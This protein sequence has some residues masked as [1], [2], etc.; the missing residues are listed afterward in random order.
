MNKLIII[1][2]TLLMPL[3]AAAERGT[4]MKV[5]VCGE[6]NVLIKM[7]GGMYIA[8]E[9]FSGVILLEGEVVYGNLKTYGFEQISTK[10]KESGTFFVQECQS[11]NIGDA[12]KVLCD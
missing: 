8:A 3:Y 12:T 6:G 2:I 5:D 1:L 11:D 4:V 10:N 9:Y 7:A